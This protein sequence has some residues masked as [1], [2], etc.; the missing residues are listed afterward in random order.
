MALTA[1]AAVGRVLRR[2]WGGCRTEAAAFGAGG[3]AAAAA[4]VAWPAPP[5]FLFVWQM[6]QT[7]AKSEALA[8]VQVWQ[9]QPM[10]MRQKESGGSEQI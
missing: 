3:T 6:L 4:E 1:R 9:I 2:C 8:K 5:E 10:V 7:G